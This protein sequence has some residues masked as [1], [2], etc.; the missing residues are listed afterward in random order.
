MGS[1]L[2]KKKT[3]QISEKRP[4]ISKV[5]KQGLNG[6]TNMDE[7]GANTVGRSAK[8]TSRRNF[9]KG[10]D[11]KHDLQVEVNAEASRMAMPAMLNRYPLINIDHLSQ[12]D[13]STISYQ[14]RHRKI[15]RCRSLPGQGKEPTRLDRTHSRSAGF[16]EVYLPADATSRVRILSHDPAYLSH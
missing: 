4:R 12:S 14:L 5:R 1:T 3:L 16:P 2:P 8:A 11:S 10:L 13:R 6:G 7:K 15:I 9:H